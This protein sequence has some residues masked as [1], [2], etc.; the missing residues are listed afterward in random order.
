M[1]VLFLPLCFDP[2][3]TIP[4]E[5][6]KVT[7]FR[8]GVA[9]MALAAALSLFFNSQNRP[10]LREVVN[11]RLTLPVLAYAGVYILATVTSV[12]PRLSLWGSSDK[13]GTV[14]MLSAVL[15]FLLIAGALRTREQVERLITAL[16]LS[17]VPVTAYGLA[18]YLGLDPL[19]WMTD[20]VSAVLSTM[21]RSNF[22]G[23]YLAMVTPFTLSRLI[24]RPGG[25]GWLRYILVLILQII[26][27]FLTLARGAW[28]SFLGGCLVFL[29][30]LAHR[31]R[32]WTLLAISIAVLVTGSW[33]F[34]SMNG[35]GLPRQA[36]NAP[37][38]S[39]PSF[40]E[41]RMAS[42]DR[43]LM[44]W[45]S[46]LDLI[47]ARWLLGYGPETYVG[48]FSSHC[49]PG[50]LYQG[51]DI[52]VD[53]PHNLILDQLMAAGMVGLL[54]FGWVVM[55][56]YRI[57]FNAFNHGTDRYREATAAAVLSSVTA[58]L[59]QAQ[60]NPD[61]IVLVALFWLTLALGIVVGR[62]ELL[63]PTPACYH[64]E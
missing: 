55:R 30:L 52:V 54:A 27:L 60:L 18:Q 3:A 56:F 42:V 26:C 43:R 10:F 57:T 35:V 5:P 39:E 21:G 49:P 32:S 51:T 16:L 59:I 58:F 24:S 7:L 12:A 19:D 38:E 4:F 44:I 41:L 17:S 31:W 34:A 1:L 45:R 14:T 23:A 13:H 8:V 63:T 15:F 22:L 36:T 6:V 61:V 40:S 47:P 29:G 46:T 64:H 62:W 20:S 11:N 33:L 50:S 2:L 53:D 28:L 9:G 48:V 25:G 37:Q